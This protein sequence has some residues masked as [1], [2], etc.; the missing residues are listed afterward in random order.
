MLI[1]DYWVKSGSMWYTDAVEQANEHYK[2]G[3]DSEN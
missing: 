2:R 3:D 1:M